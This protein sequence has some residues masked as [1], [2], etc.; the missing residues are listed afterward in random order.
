MAALVDVS[1]VGAGF[2]L[3]VLAFATMTPHLFLGRALWTGAALLLIALSILYEWLFM[4][5]G[6]GTPGMRYAQIALCSF[7]DDN[8]TRGSMRARVGATLL[9]TLPL[10]LGLLWAVFDEDRLG[11]QDRMTRTYQ[12]SYR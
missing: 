9:A 7:E 12:R 8:P 6:T 3:F 2:L 10:G 5:Y 1:L 4:S 11:W